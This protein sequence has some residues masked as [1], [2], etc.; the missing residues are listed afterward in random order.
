[1]KHRLLI[2]FLCLSFISI[3]AQTYLNETARWNQTYSWSGFDAHTSC[4]SIYYIAGDSV[5]NDTSYYKV[6]LQ[7]LCYYTHIVYD[8]LG[9]GLQVVDTNSTDDLSVLIREYNKQFIQR[10]NESEYLLYNFELSDF[11]AIETATPYP[12]CGVGSVSL[13]THDTVC[14]GSIGRKRWMISMSN[15]PLAFY[16]IEGVGPSSGFRAPICRNGCPECGYGLTSFVLNGDTLYHGNCS[17]TGIEE[18]KDLDDFSFHY[19]MN[20]LSFQ[21]KDLHWV[22]LYSSIGFR[23]HII[24]AEGGKV[25][26]NTNQMVSGV[27][28]YGAWIDGKMRSGKVVISQ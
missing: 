3:N 6:N 7:S 11:T 19:G 15:Y 10:S 4:T 27:Y 24:R 20:Y 12:S 14:I 17:I 23:T 18:T 22:E 2:L 5:I 8:S 16:F 25:E 21:A 26:L 9:N 28:V 1:M 13:L